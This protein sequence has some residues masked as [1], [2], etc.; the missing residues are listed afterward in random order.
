MNETYDQKDWGEKAWGNRNA[1]LLL[2]L[3]MKPKVKDAI[4]LLECIHSILRLT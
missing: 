1:N 4:L 3:E 2:Q